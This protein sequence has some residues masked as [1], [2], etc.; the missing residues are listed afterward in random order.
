MCVGVANELDRSVIPV[1]TSVK[2]SVARHSTKKM[3]IL[4][5]RATMEGELLSVQAQ[6]NAARRLREKIDI[7]NKNDTTKKPENFMSMVVTTDEKEKVLLGIRMYPQ[8]IN[9][10]Q[11]PSKTRVSGDDII[12]RF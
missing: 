1:P 3:H 7:Y 11:H 9:T 8:K 12:K 5:T 10:S 4:Y 6:M 2:L